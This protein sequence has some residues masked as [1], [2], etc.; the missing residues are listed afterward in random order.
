MVTRGGF[1]LI[2]VLVALTLLG[3]AL[4]GVAASSLF[5]AR[6]LRRADDS[7]RGALEALQILDSLAQETAPAA[8]AR[9]TGR[10]R[11]AWQLRPDSHALRV[12]EV[13]VTYVDGAAHNTSTYRL[14]QPVESR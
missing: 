14:L 3:V 4:L 1:G 2:E 8:G 13:S 7:E 5:A 6:L 9:S 10:V 12:L 11:L